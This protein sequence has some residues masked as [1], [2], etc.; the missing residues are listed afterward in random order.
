[1]VIAYGE[2]LFGDDVKVGRPV[3]VTLET[4]AGNTFSKTV[5]SGRSV[6]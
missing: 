3:F 1:M 2:T 4:G 6:G 5:I